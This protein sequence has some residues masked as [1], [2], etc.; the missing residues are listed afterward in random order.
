MKE[1]KPSDTRQISGGQTTRDFDPELLGIDPMQIPR[2]E[3]NDVDSS[4]V[5]DPAAVAP[6]AQIPK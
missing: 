5:A 6:R 4:S 1:I 3:P 2:A